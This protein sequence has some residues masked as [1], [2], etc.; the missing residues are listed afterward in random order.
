MLDTKLLRIL[1]DIVG[2]EHVSSA[3]ADRICYSYDATQQQHQPDVVVYPADAGQVSR[4]LQLANREGIPVYPRGA[5]SGFTGGS[6]PVRGGI[7]LVLTRLNRILRIDQDNLVAEVEP[8]VVT[9]HLQEAVEAVGL[10]YPPDPASL[11]FSTIGGNV[12]E[13]A[14]GPRC[15]KYGV[16]KDYVLGLEVVTPQGDIIRTGGETMKGVV[17]YDLT[18]LL[19]GSEGT[20]GVITRITLKLLPKPAAKKTMLVLF[21]SIDGAAQAVSAIIRGKIIPTTL[22]FMDATAIDC[23]RQNANLDLPEAARALLII[24]VD[25][26]AEMLEKQSSRILDI[27]TPLGVVATQVA[28]TAEESEAIWRVRR[29]VSPSLR[30]VNPDKYNEDICVPRS[31][32]PDMIRAIEAIARRLEIPIVNFGHAGDGNIHV[33]IMVN[34]ALPGQEEKAEEAIRDI[35]AETIRLGGTMSGEHGVGVTK[36]PYLPMELDPAAVL[37]MKAIKRALDPNNIL[38]PGKIFP[39]EPGRAVNEA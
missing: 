15:V 9:A 39:E 20:L 18:K 24:E 5:G 25:G 19:V 4:I 17:G 6:L 29:S 8:G 38:N 22:E 12:A 37:Y 2:P 28:V 26:D 30:R 3:P 31:R 16:T 27:V 35:F 7:S 36:A 10:F 11:K 23:V 1:Q 32:L 14:G 21:D 34:R 13:C 33:N